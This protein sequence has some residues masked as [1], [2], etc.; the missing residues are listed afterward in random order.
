M[1][2]AES[3]QAVAVERQAAASHRIRPRQRAGDRGG[4]G[5]DRR[6]P[7]ESLGRHPR[8]IGPPAASDPDPARRGSWRGARPRPAR[9]APARRHRGV[10]P[11]Y[12]TVAPSPSDRPGSVGARDASRRAGRPR[13]L[14]A[15]D[16]DHAA[17]TLIRPIRG[18]STCRTR[19]VR[20]TPPWRRTASTTRTTSRTRR[21]R[22]GSRSSPAP[23]SRPRSAECGHQSFASAQVS[24][25]PTSTASAGSSG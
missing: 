7:H 1:V 3:A 12:R 4:R 10:Q 19:P 9:L 5:E 20:R 11:P 6:P 15:G 8:R 18:S 22:D 16:R 25:T 17:W 24:P 23:P 2:E 14:L 13:R 21:G